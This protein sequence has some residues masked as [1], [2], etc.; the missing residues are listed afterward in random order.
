[1]TITFT[2]F[3]LC[4]F[5]AT[6][7]PLVALVVLD[8]IGIN[9]GVVVKTIYH[10]VDEYFVDLAYQADCLG[11]PSSLGDLFFGAIEVF[12][13]ADMA[14]GRFFRGPAAIQ[15]F[16]LFLAVPAVLAAILTMAACL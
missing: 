4:V 7:L 14:I 13:R 6:T 5:C 2:L 16:S 10:N 1:M 3:I 8:T 9:F 11:K 15:G 12:L